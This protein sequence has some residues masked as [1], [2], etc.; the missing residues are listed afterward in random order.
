MG[1][2]GHPRLESKTTATGGRLDQI[3]AKHII[4]ERSGFIRLACRRKANDMALLQHTDL[5]PLL[6]NTIIHATAY[7]IA[8]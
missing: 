7:L 4:V 8:D 1:H 6:L 2:P 3:K 5:F